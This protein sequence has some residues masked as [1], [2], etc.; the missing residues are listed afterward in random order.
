ME[1][2]RAKDQV[3]RR[4][5]GQCYLSL[6]IVQLPIHD[7]QAS[8]VHRHRHPDR[9]LR[10]FRSVSH[11]VTYCKQVGA[12]DVLYHR[13]WLK[14]YRAKALTAYLPLDFLG[15]VDAMRRCLPDLDG[16]DVLT[17]ATEVDYV[18]TC[19]LPY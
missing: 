13:A 6:I 1:I 3:I 15:H 17:R 11:L 4:R 18:V 12:E 2:V 5:E 10:T 9:S 8:L 16:P 19:D 14:L 7:T